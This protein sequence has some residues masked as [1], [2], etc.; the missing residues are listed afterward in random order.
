MIRLDP[1]GLTE[2]EERAVRSLKR[3]AKRW[4]RSLMLYSRSG[5]LEVHHLT[6]QP[7]NEA[8]P[9]DTIYG[10]TNDGGDT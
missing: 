10:I 6:N 5:T 8:E 9:L 7:C 4:P 2:D 1:E 3:V